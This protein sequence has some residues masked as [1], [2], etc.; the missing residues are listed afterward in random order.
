MMTGS[1][2]Q[3]AR[4]TRWPW[5][6]LVWGLPEQTNWEGEKPRSKNE[7]ARVSEAVQFVVVMTG[8]SG[9]EKSSRKREARAYLT[10]YPSGCR[11]H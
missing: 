4:R 2:E 3:M 8:G 7:N 5:S 1:E 6:V 10:V 9:D 11:G